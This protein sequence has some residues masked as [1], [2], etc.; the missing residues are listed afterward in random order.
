MLVRHDVLGKGLPSLLSNPIIAPC[1]LVGKSN[2]DPEGC[3]EQGIHKS[4][5]RL[6]DYEVSERVISCFRGFGKEPG[7]K[8]Y[9]PRKSWCYV[10]KDV[11][12]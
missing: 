11:L 5:S 9:C 1:F 8:A 6:H 2:R 3:E 10:L 12:M 4:I 7:R